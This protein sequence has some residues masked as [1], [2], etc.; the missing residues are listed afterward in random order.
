MLNKGWKWEKDSW[1]S[2]SSSFIPLSM[3]T[4]SCCVSVFLTHAELQHWLVWILT[5]ACEIKRK[6]RFSP[7]SIP[8]LVKQKR[9]H[10][11]GYLVTWESQPHHLWREIKGVGPVDGPRPMAGAA[12]LPGHA[13]FRAGPS[14]EVLIRLKAELFRDDL[15]IERFWL[16]SSHTFV[17][18]EAERKRRGEQ[19]DRP[20]SLLIFDSEAESACNL[21]IQAASRYSRE[22]TALKHWITHRS[23]FLKGSVV[24]HGTSLSF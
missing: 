5:V 16:R 24:S 1:C 11:C 22:H 7:P 8:S 19:S 17:K 18:E 6:Q 23:I 21:C 9:Y 20:F 3:I 10:S 2:R 15:F 13:V 12:L 14:G 4:H